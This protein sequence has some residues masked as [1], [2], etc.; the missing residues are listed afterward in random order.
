MK[1]NGMNKNKA[2]IAATLIM[3]VVMIA[4]AVIAS[5]LGV[6][7]NTISVGIAITLCMSVGVIFPMFITTSKKN[8]SK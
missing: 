8:N 6:A 4:G 7:A 1:N 3:S 2:M 5:R